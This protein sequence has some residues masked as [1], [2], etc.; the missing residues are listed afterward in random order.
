MTATAPTST[1]RR[2]AA[3]VTRPATAPL[4]PVEPRG[5][6]AGPA[7]RLLAL[8][9]DPITA[10]VE[11]VRT[12]LLAGAD[13]V[14]ITAGVD[15]DLNEAFVYANEQLE[16]AARM[17]AD[18][19]ISDL[20]TFATVA[21][22]FPF[23]PRTPLGAAVL[24]VP[25]ASST[26]VVYGL[27]ESM[28][29]T[30]G[31][32][33]TAVRTLGS[34]PRRGVPAVAVVPWLAEVALAAARVERLADVVVAHLH[35]TRHPG[36]PELPGV[37]GDVELYPGGRAAPQRRWALRSRVRFTPGRV[38]IVSAAGRIS[39]GQGSPIG[40]LLW[41]A[42]PVTGEVESVSAPEEGWAANLEQDPLGTVHVLDSAGRSLVALT[43]S[44]W[45][46]QATTVVDQALVDSTAGDLPLGAARGVYALQ[47]LG[48]TRGA[49]TIGVPLLRGVAHP[50]AAA[51][52]HG[53]V[54]AGEDRQPYR[55]RDLLAPRVAIRRRQRR[56]WWNTDLGPGTAVSGW[57]RPAAPWLL[58]VAPL[59]I[60]PGGGRNAFQVGV[61]LLALV[62]VAEP[63]LSW[64]LA[65]LR[66]AVP[67][68]TRLAV[69][70]PAAPGRPRLSL[71]ERFLVVRSASGH[72]TWVPGPQD[73][74]LGVTR[75]VRLL[76]SDVAWGFAL[77]DARGRWRAV[78]PA[79]EWAPTGRY[80]ELEAFARTARL[81][82]AEQEAPPLP[83]LAQ[84]N[85][86]RGSRGAADRTFGPRPR[87]LVILGL[88][89]TPAAL[90]TL[91][92]P[93]RSQWLALTTLLLTYGGAAVISVLTH[94]RLG[95]T[96]P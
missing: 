95:R 7:T 69:Y 38:E 20:P 78:L 12:A 85:A 62:V 79:A 46:S 43:V 32:L 27:R 77:S 29:A 10:A 65:L 76:S 40:S 18:T 67:R 82:L 47:S 66:D 8:G 72:E 45:A 91:A 90:L 70:S 74:D 26:E 61:M 44:D 81:E 36:T 53:S 87:A 75:L 92:G 22:P 16:L 86:V 84:E 25:L 80:E 63:W 39:V 11:A 60:W 42:P 41:V 89:S 2:F 48:F 9:G 15:A 51:D 35:A 54:R 83:R 71:T 6:V 31:G 58:A 55:G 17:V 3:R 23:E 68:P 59:V 1:A 5:T 34:V 21:Q 13:A 33:A 56:R 88:V 28:R 94:R 93:A 96:T 73:A 57:L 4:P 24:D 19:V 52:G 14:E 50:P 30:L 37:G 64:L 49:T